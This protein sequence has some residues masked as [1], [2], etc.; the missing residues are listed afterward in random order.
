MDHAPRGQ[1]RG[2]L[3]GHP[4]APR[5]ARAKVFT[6]RRVL[7]VTER[8]IDRHGQHLL[9]PADEVHGHLPTTL[10]ASRPPTPSA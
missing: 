3:R 6:L 8:T 10:V 5:A 7:R 9:V 2:G 4:R 1:A